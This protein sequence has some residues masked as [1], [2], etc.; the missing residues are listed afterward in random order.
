MSAMISL[1]DVRSSE[2]FFDNRSIGFG[3]NYHF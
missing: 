1:T 2:D 3:V